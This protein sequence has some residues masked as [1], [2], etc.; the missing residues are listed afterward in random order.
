MSEIK[1]YPTD[2]KEAAELESNP[3]WVTKNIKTVDG[4]RVGIF[5]KKEEPKVKEPKVKGGA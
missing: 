2:S 4:V 5:E 3:A 1:E